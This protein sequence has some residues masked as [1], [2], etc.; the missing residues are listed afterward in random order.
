MNLATTLK[1]LISQFQ[2][3]AFYIYL[4]LQCE[5]PLTGKSSTVPNEP[6]RVLLGASYI[7]T[8]TLTRNA[9]L[10]KSFPRLAPTGLASLALGY[11]YVKHTKGEMGK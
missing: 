8:R 2:I 9:L 6:P 5:S 10:A 4:H 1:M 7:I 3:P 11:I